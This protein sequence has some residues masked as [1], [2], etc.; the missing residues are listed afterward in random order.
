MEDGSVGAYGFGVEHHDPLIHQP[1][2][3]LGTVGGGGGGG[4][5][6]AESTGCILVS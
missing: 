3:E 6:T 2:A 5:V 1:L 4:G